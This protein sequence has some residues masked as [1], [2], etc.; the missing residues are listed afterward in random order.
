ME[1]VAFAIQAVVNNIADFLLAECK[2][3]TIRCIPA[4]VFKRTSTFPASEQQVHLLL[5]RHP[6]TSNGG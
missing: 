2:L 1:L 3:A 4:I 6:S 5:F